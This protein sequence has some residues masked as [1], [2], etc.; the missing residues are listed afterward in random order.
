MAVR[1]YEFQVPYGVVQTDGER[2]VSID[3]KPVNHF[4]VNAGIYVLSPTVF[5]LISKGQRL[6]M[7]KLFE[8]VMASKRKSAA[9]PIC[10]YWIDIGQMD[11]L[12]RAKTDFGVNFA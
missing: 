7:P 10:E 3:E 2:I 11:D 9:Y 8:R 12:E 4:F 5:E 1:E 6:D